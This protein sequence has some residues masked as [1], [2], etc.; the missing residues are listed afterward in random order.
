MQT[1]KEI[2]T[3]WHNGTRQAIAEAL[4]KNSTLKT[5]EMGYNPFD[6]K[7]G[8]ALAEGLKFQNSIDT[9][10]LMWCKLGGEGA[11]AFGEVRHDL[12][13]A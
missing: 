4:K 3:F 9:V 2:K 12:Y 1:E 11:A 13:D 8:K 6:E 5:L 10:K 7:G